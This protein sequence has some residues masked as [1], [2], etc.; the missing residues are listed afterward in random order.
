VIL[1]GVT[2][3]YVDKR[4]ADM[5]VATDIRIRAA[6]RLDVAS[7][8]VIARAAYA[9]YVEIIGRAPAPMLA[10]FATHIDNDF[11]FLAETAEQESRCLGYA[12]LVD[13]AQGWM[14]ENIAVVPAAQGCGV[15]HMLVRHCEAFL[16]GR[17]ARRYCLYTNTA[18]TRNIGWYKALGFIETDRRVENGFSRVYFEKRL[19]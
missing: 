16:H 8:S 6:N 1:S 7:L 9:E 3:F 17:S 18:M 10:D 11:V 12:V 5:P 19:G 2:P 4:I 13:G 14:L 15:G